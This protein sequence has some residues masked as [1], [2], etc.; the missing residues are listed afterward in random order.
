[1]LDALEAGLCRQIF[2]G[3]LATQAR[4]CPSCSPPRTPIF[5]VVA[6]MSHLPD[7]GVHGGAAE[8]AE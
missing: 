4:R 5:T 2:I 7:M 1:M 8:A 3:M 6:S